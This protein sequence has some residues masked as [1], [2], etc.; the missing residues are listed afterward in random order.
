MRRLLPLLLVAL[1][2]FSANNIK[3]QTIYY[4]AQNGTG[5]GSSWTNASGDLQGMIDTAAAHSGGQVWVAK[6]TY[7]PASGKYF[8][9]SNNVAVYGGFA[10]NESALNARNFVANITTLQ[11]NGSS[12][13][14]NSNLNSTAIL[15]GFTITGGTGY[16]D[17]NGGGMYNTSSSPTIS[18]CTF[19]GNSITGNSNGAGMYNY[20]SSSPIINNCTFSNNISSLYGG[21]M[22][23]AF[24]STPTI[25]N[26]TFTSNSAVY[27][28]GGMENNHSSPTISNCTFTLNTASESNG[29]G[30][31]MDNYYSTPTVVNCTFSG[32]NALTGIGGGMSNIYTSSP[33][34][35]NCIFINN[36]AGNSGGGM[37]NNNGALPIITNC[38]F[39][40][41]SAVTG[42]CMY[43]Y[44]SATPTLSLLNFMAVV[45][46]FLM[47]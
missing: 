39:S 22:C 2:Q 24:S 15:D 4:V 28:G 23:N 38:T 34:I 35:R 47:I 27:F 29:G 36:T 45:Y 32:N 42:G 5:N 18:N 14:Y 33:I 26:C 11:G 1:L 19:S 6:G 12:V 9:M 3:A 16:T 25:S 31:G 40:G 13:I 30:G 10:G 8:S 41:N 43:S 17:G 21:G 46:Q 20:N 7:Q 37:N 44:S